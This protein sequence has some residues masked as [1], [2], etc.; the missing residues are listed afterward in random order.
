M[1][2]VTAVLRSCALCV[3]LFVCVW[4][5]PVPLTEAGESRQASTREVTREDFFVPHV[6]TV[7]AN[8]GQ[9]V[10]ISVRRIT[11]QDKPPTRGPVLFTNSGFTSS[12]VMFDLDY[13]SYSIATALAEQ[14]FDV[15][16]MD[17]TGFGRSPRPT[18]DDP[19]NVDPS[20][21][22]LLIPK[23]LSARCGASYPHHLVTIFTEQAEID[24]VV[25]SI[26][27]KTGR[28]RISLAGWSRSMFRFG[29]YAA[30]HPDKI[31]R[32]AI[33]GPGYRRDA[34]SDFPIANTPSS[35]PSRTSAPQFS[36]FLRTADDILA[37]W[38][39]QRRC[40]DT[41][42]PGIHEALANAVHRYADPGAVTWGTPPGTFYRIANGT[43]VDTGWNRMSASRV[44]APVLLV[45]GEHD[46]RSAEEVPNLYADIGSRE[47]ILLTAQCATHFLPFERNHKTLHNAFAEFLTKGTVDGRQGVM[48]VD[49]NGN[50][51]PAPQTVVYTNDGERI[52]AQLF[53][54]AGSGPFPL[55]IHV[56]SGPDTAAWGPVL[57]RVLGDAGY[58]TMV[59]TIRGAP[60]EPARRVEGMKRAAE[61]IVAAIEH[62]TRDNAYRI[63]G[64]R[65]AIMGYSAGGTVAVITGAMSDRV[66]AVITQAP[67]S[68]GWSREPA[69]RE[70]VIAAARRLR[71][72]TLCLVAEN[73]NTTESARS[74]CEAVKE[75]G[76]RSNLIVYPAFT[77]HLPSTNPE[78]APG[79][80][81]F[82]REDGIEVWRKEVLAFLEK[83]LRE[84]R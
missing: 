78:V 4:P 3:F 48:T 81:L 80:M 50:Y 28:D 5:Q 29:L 8:A 32:L 76:A 36:F 30:Q 41:F 20:Q 37:P 2:A 6:S 19:C 67:S 18:M 38:A 49:R 13:K 55:V 44:K 74:V 77:P 39:R 82:G 35:G 57:A 72:P 83:S 43:Q 31:E 47:K 42:D 34:P 58:A 75:W 7:P 17:H 14:S 25:D 68:V 10:G 46:P 66:R 63:D 60:F 56:H 52:E 70:A 1:R 84:S 33:V 22:Q 64:Q 59:S 9:T 71:V 61:D 21:Q 24:S 79:H 51:V 15:Y 62:L 40:E 27:M 73:D 53:T 54:P 12:L 45:V 23:P 26:R 69:L 11:R 16:L 65:V